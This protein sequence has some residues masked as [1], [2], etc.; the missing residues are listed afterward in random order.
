LIVYFLITPQDIIKALDGL[1][2]EN[3]PCAVLAANALKNAVEDYLSTR[4]PA[5]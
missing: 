1:P 4:E 5:F 3:K 2:E